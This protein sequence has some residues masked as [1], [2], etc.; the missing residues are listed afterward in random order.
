MMAGPHKRT[1]R[2]PREVPVLTA[3]E[4]AFLSA[5]SA[6]E[7]AHIF[8]LEAV[9]KAYAHT[10]RLRPDMTALERE[11]LTLWIANDLSARLV[12]EMPEQSEALKALTAEI[13]CACAR[14]LN[15]SIR[16]TDMTQPHQHTRALLKT[17]RFLEE[18]TRPGDTPRVPAHIHDTARQLLL[19]FPGFDEIEAAH[20]ALPEVFGPVV[21]RQAEG[22]PA[23]GKRGKRGD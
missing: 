16:S 9:S 5:I 19:H 17:M 22:M 18:L 13:E 14:W 11:Y 15:G 21:Q 8:S 3:A 4:E 1:A 10:K 12:E 2:P 20:K 23:P 7:N 6:P